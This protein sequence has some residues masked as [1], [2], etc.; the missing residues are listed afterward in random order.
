MKLAGELGDRPDLP[1]LAVTA[2]SPT[3]DLER[4]VHAIER[5]SNYPYQW[6]F[7]R[8]LR[9]RMRRKA[10]AWPGAFDLAPLGGVWTIRRFDDV[11]TAPYHGFQGASHYYREAS[12][13]RVAERI[14]LPVLILTAADDPFVPPE[15]FRESELR[16]NP[17]VT[18]RIETHGGHCGFV[19][20]TRGWAR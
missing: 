16:T 7:V 18:V 11:Y 15:Q 14:R 10:G 6:N 19:G 9:N 13:L 4:C 1:V 5:R 12:A 20:D 3:I 8:N 17:H 2:V